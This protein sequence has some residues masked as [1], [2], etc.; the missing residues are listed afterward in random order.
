MLCPADSRNP[1]SLAHSSETQRLLSFDMQ[2]QY[3]YEHPFNNPPLPDPRWPY[4]SSLSYHGT[5][6]YMQ[7]P[8]EDGL[9]PL[10]VLTY[11]ILRLGGPECRNE[12]H[13]SRS[14][15]SPAQRPRDQYLRLLH[16]PSFRNHNQIILVQYRDRPCDLP[17]DNWP[18]DW[19]WAYVSYGDS[20]LY[21]TFPGAGEPNFDAL[22]VDLTTATALGAPDTDA[23][24]LMHAAQA[25]L[26]Y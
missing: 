26:L 15:A 25:L 12:I 19:K 23:P 10:P 14:I 13:F 5:W 1:S 2:P 18:E 8:G 4:T 20:L 9:T 24:L 16:C 21:P 6:P 3:G 11:D 17:W 7:Q 22:E